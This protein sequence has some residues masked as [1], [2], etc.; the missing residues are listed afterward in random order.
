MR[1]VVWQTV[2]FLF[3]IRLC[4]WESYRC[5]LAQLLFRFGRWPGIWHDWVDLSHAIIDDKHC[6][7]RV[8]PEIIGVSEAEVEHVTL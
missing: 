6:Q 2:S 4:H 3:L 8:V 5:R 1:L 7:G